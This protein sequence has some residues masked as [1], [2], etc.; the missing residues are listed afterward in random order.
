M[1]LP[2]LYLSH[3]APPLLDDELWKSQLVDWAGQIQKPKGILVISAHWENA[4]VAISS[5]TANTPLIYD[6]GGFAPRFYNEKYATPDAAWLGSLVASVM[7]DHEPLHQS[8]NRG[9]DHGA[10]VPIKIMYPDADIPVIQLSLPT[11]DP[12]KLMDLGRRLKPLRDHGVLIVGSG[13]MTHGLPF[14]REFRI[15]APAPGWSTE[16]DIWAKE[17]LDRGDLESLI[18]YKTLAPGMPYAHPTVEH[19]TPLFVTL[20]A[21]TDMESAV[22]E[23]IDGY[24]MGLSKRSF[25]V[26]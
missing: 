10:W 3:G 17:A 16:F 1:T 4:P 15:D 22:A 23:K 11:H 6:F 26:V 25:E 24:W 21:A 8:A 19:F 20:G 14:L 13:F 5:T 9:I 2:A 12:V 18:N 7:P